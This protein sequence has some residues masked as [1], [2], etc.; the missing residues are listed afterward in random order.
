[1]DGDPTFQFAGLMLSTIPALLIYMIFQNKIIKGMS[2][3]AIK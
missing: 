2:A 1:Y 3:G